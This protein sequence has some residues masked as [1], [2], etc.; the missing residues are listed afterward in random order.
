MKILVHRT[1]D[2][3][4]YYIRKHNGLCVCCGEKTINNRRMCQR[5]AEL[6]RQYNLNAK[7]ARINRRE[8]FWSSLA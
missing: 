2:M 7:L 6:H 3:R 8:K 5:H 4:R 1:A